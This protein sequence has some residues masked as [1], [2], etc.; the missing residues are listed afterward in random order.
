M[1]NANNKRDNSYKFLKEGKLN[2]DEGAGTLMAMQLI[3]KEY[4]KDINE[5]KRKYYN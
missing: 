1:G 2:V 4:K 5:C 3:E